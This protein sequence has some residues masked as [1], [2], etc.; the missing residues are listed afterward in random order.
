MKTHFIVCRGLFLVIMVA[1]M[2]ACA[3]TDMGGNVY[4]RDLA[5][6][7]QTVKLGTIVALK[8]VRIEGTKSGVGAVSGGVLGAVLGNTVGSGSGKT[9]AQVGGAVAGTYAGSKVEEAIS[10]QKAWEIIVE[11]PEGEAVAIVQ[12]A[13][14]VWSVGE[15]VRVLKANDGTMRVTKL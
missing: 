14:E 13:T 10:S 7:P 11:Y 2:S 8:E 4:S 5:R 12:G 9:V 3:T 6:S 15:K 1:F